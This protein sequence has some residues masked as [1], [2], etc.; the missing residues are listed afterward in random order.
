ME[1]AFGAFSLV[2]FGATTRR[3]ACTIRARSRADG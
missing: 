2:T 3:A 1:D